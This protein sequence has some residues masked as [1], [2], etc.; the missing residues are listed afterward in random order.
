[1]DK[2]EENMSGI[3]Y[4]VGVGPGDPELLTLKAARI[5][6]GADIIAAPKKGNELG[7][8]F[9]I[10][11]KAVPEIRTKEILPLDFPMTKDQ[12]LLS[13]AH[14]EAA[15]KIE[16]FLRAGKTVALIT[17][18]DPTLYSTCSYVTDRV[19][20][21]GYPVEY[22]SGVPSFCAAAAKIATALALGEESILVSDPEKVD[23]F[24]GDTLVILKAGKKLRMLK[25]KLA[26]SGRDVYLVEN[27]GMPGEK[28][29][30]GLDNIPDEAGYLSLII[31]VSGG[32][33][34]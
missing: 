26:D 9:Q 25:S 6:T 32:R 23:L 10:A 27:C 18:G 30:H 34:S 5:L 21:K 11:E 24:C 15:G 12:E 19:R 28:I 20:Q 1:L 2:K 31:V 8:A 4:A 14:D 17:L 16:T 29:Y 22:I 33:I 7:V 13:K 3:L